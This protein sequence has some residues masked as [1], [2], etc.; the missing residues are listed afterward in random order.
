MDE[1]EHTIEALLR[2]NR[3]W[4]ARTEKAE[5]EVAKPDPVPAPEPSAVCAGA[6]QDEVLQAFCSEIKANLGSIR[7]R[8]GIAFG[9]DSFALCMRVASDCE[10]DPDDCGQAPDLEAAIKAFGIDWTACRIDLPDID[11]AE[12]DRCGGRGTVAG[13]LTCLMCSGSGE[14][15]CECGHLHECVECEGT[16]KASSDLDCDACHSKGY[17]V[18]GR[19]GEWVTVAGVAIPARH[20]HKIKRHLP[21]AVVQAVWDYGQDA[22]AFSCGVRTGDDCVHQYR[23]IVMGRVR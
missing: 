5:A 22:L 8:N 11:V 12:C 7:V 14:H 13:K 2:D 16:G 20:Y 23:G 17:F 10:V 21:G 3:A 15:R 18:E 9:S 19:A 1:S 4:R 6:V